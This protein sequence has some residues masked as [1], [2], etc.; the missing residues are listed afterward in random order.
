MSR[1]N[2][3]NKNYITNLKGQLGNMC[4]DHRGIENMRQ[5]GNKA[6]VNRPKKIIK[7]LKLDGSS[8]IAGPKREELPYV[9]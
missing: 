4:M 6:L 5:S 8:R 7:K 3:A 2:S 1:P 9:K